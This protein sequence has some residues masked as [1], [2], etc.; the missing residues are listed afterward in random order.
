MRELVAIEHDPRTGVSG[1]AEVLDARTTIA[2]WRRVDATA[3]AL[4]DDLDTL[5]GLLVMGGP[6][7]AVDPSAH[8]WMAS[9]LELLDEAVRAHVPVLG[10]CLGAQLLATALGG[11][12]ERLDTPEVGYLPLHRTEEAHTD[13][14][15]GGWPDGSYAL[16][17][18]EDGVISLPPEATALLTG[19]A[20]VPAWRFGS[21]HAV[22]LHP[23]V[24]AE[25]L[26]GWVE[27]DSIKAMLERA[28][29]VGDALV[30]EAR[31]RDKVTPPLGK[32][33]L[34]RWIDGPVKARA[35][36]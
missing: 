7:S 29:V 8:A 12:V 9:E 21:A 28:E 24:D 10:V 32:A 36:A 2:P 5:A 35:A 4:P 30:E 15:A 23:E 25:Q 33:L 6:M 14:V 34:G 17:S 26:A 11:E 22:Q 18:H 16:L 27:I 31:R 3:D 13:P 1:F 19:G 20:G